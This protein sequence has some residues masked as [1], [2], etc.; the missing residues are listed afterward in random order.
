MVG[1]HK[2]TG[3]G[4]VYT[5]NSQTSAPHAYHI[6]QQNPWPNSL[7]SCMVNYSQF[8]VVQGKWSHLKVT[9]ALMDIWETN[10]SRSNL[11]NSQQQYLSELLVNVYSYHVMVKSVPCCCVHGSHHFSNL[12]RNSNI[13]VFK[14]NN[15]CQNT[16]NDSNGMVNLILVVTIVLTGMF[17]VITLTYVI[18]APVV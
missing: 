7:A 18:V 14:K 2:V 3:K 11:G 13:I 16:T 15:E 17:I 12:F 1:N 9:W 4:Y 10:H 8:L 5:E 6:K